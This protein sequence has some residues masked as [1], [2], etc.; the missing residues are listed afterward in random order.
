MHIY[1]SRSN[2]A[3]ASK[4]NST[5][6]HA[7]NK[8][9]IHCIQYSTEWHKNVLDRSIRTRFDNDVSHFEPGPQEHK[10]CISIGPPSNAEEPSKLND[11]V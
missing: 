8:R 5:L 11:L 7:L 9:I 10:W 6:I 4:H 2:S 3:F 1:T